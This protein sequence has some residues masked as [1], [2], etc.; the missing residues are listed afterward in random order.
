MAKTK[1]APAKA[2]SKAP[3]ATDPAK[4]SNPKGSKKPAVKAGIKRK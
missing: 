3:K 1:S 2:V 4:N